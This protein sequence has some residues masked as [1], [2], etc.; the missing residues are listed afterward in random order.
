MSNET[1]T[2]VQEA[3][4][5]QETCYPI[6]RELRKLD[7]AVRD[8]NHNAAL[9]MRGAANSLEKYEYLKESVRDLQET[10]RDGTDP[11][12]VKITVAKLKRIFG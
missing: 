4:F 12:A 5:N 1:E 10:L 8:G 7:E 11:M 2:G 9:I 3:P 6:I